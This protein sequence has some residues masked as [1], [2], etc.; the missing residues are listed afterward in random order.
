MHVWHFLRFVLADRK[1]ICRDR[2]YFTWIPSKSI[3]W[4]W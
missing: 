1:D 2:N 4:W 3:F